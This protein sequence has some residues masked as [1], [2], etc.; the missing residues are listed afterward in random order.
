MK[1]MVSRVSIL[2]LNSGYATLGKDKVRA[3]MNIT[4]FPIK[5]SAIMINASYDVPEVIGY[6]FS[7]SPHLAIRK[8]PIFLNFR[9]LGWAAMKRTEIKNTYFFPECGLICNLFIIYI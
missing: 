2:D 6:T 8:S 3:N 1:S 4:I 7:F 9:R 5:A